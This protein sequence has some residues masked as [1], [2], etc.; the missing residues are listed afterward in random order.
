MCPVKKESSRPDKPGSVRLLRAVPSFI[1]VHRRQR[2][3]QQ[4]THPAN[5]GLAR[6]RACQPLDTGRI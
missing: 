4:P 5:S 6:F 2:T 3:H 1:W